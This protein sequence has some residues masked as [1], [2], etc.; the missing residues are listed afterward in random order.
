MNQ[1][2]LDPFARK[3]YPELLETY[4][5]E[6]GSFAQIS[7]FNRRGALLASGCHNGLVVIWVSGCPS[8][9]L[10]R[11]P[12]LFFFFFFSLVSLS[13]LLSHATWDRIS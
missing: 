3:S 4:I 6:P 2:L 5:Y 10:W 8:D 1:A 11:Q 13:S 7:K 12:A 9:M